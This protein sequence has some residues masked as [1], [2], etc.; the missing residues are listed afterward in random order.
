MDK[1]IIKS[2]KKLRKITGA[3]IIQCK[4]SLEKNNYD[5]NLSIDYIRKSNE[6]DFFEKKNK[7]LEGIVIGK[8]NKSSTFGVLIEINCET[9]FVSKS[10]IF[11]KKS[12]KIL[13]YAV[14]KKIEKKETL[15]K[16]FKKEMEEIKLKTKE[17][18]KINKIKTLKGERI[19]Y[20]LHGTKM[21]SIVSLINKKKNKFEKY[22]AMQIIANKPEYLNK[23]QIPKNII[24]HEF[25]IQ[26]EIAKKNTK[27]K[28]EIEKITN[29]KTKEFIKKI[30]LMEQNFI[31]NPQETIFNLTKKNKIKIIK[32]HWM[33]V[34]S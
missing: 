10:S 16:K 18:I 27:N 12:K 11:L 3:G 20:Y 25:K 9:D 24:N 13:E 4:K 29:K 31:I 21:G 30:T 7:K 1:N 6:V 2:I 5:I 23:K 22:I 26:K 28:N 33:E 17:Q 15:I 32:F 8:T 34:G 14:L 19:I